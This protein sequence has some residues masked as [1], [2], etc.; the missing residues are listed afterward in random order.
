M[1]NGF[2]EEIASRIRAGYQCL[3]VPTSEEARCDRELE[4]VAKLLDYEII[5]WD[6][7]EGFSS[8]GDTHNT[9]N[10]CEALCTIPDSKAFSTRKALMVFKDLHNFYPN[11]DVRRAIRSLTAKRSFKNKIVHRPLI[12][13]QA[14]SA[15]HPELA[16]CATTVE[17]ELPTHAQ[18]L[19]EIDHVNQTAIEDKTKRLTSTELRHRTAQGLL[20]LTSVEAS[21]CLALCLIRHGGF[22]EE[23]IETIESIKAGVLRRSEILSYTPRNQLRKASDIGGYDEMM[24]FVT[25]RALAYTPEAAAIKLDMPKGIVLVGIPGSGKSVVTECIAQILGLPLVNFDF[26][27]VFNSL[28][29][30]SER[31]TREVISLAAAMGGCVLV[32]HQAHTTPPPAPPSPP[33]PSPRPRHS[34]RPSDAPCAEC[35]SRSPPC[36][37]PRP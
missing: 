26:S 2:Q 8:V 20:G 18:L 30:E 36:A 21:D 28:V 27:A 9:R 1:S 10:A 19:E 11:P 5:T 31:R 23:M 35:S 34:P 6:A 25:Q 15:L 32:I 37:P 22:K 7:I 4:R 13:V 33:P 14:S 29:G 3:L 16:S 12:I 24:A 17:F